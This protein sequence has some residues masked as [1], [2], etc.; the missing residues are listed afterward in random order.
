MKLTI[1][2]GRRN[3]QE[4]YDLV[5]EAYNKNEFSQMKELAFEFVNETRSS[6]EKTY[7]F[8]KIMNIS[9]IVIILFD[10]NIAI[11]YLSTHI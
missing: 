11:Y 7:K 5:V 2:K 1:I 3:L 6:K 4:I 8:N 10:I 9:C